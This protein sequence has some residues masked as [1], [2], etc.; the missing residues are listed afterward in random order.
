M[1]P[2]AMIAPVTYSLQFV[3]NLLFLE[4]HMDESRISKYVPF[5]S[6]SPSPFP[7]HIM[8]PFKYILPQDM[9]LLKT[10]PQGIL[11]FSIAYSR[12]S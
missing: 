2:L 3:S 11:T 7:G 9:S 5:P 8:I 6:P 10:S 1:L 12:P 4:T